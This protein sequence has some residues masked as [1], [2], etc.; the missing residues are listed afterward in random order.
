[1]GEFV[2]PN[3]HTGAEI[4]C[5]DG[6]LVHQLGLPLAQLALA[7]IPTLGAFRAGAHYR[8]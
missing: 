1:V 5:I 6:V 7:N 2:W 3:T 4:N 8:D